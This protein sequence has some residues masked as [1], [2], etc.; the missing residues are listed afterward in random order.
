MKK[1]HD[2]EKSGRAK[3]KQ[4]LARRLKAGAKARSQRDVVLAADASGLED[5]LTVDGLGGP[6][7]SA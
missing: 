4:A 6:S 1:K 7:Q 5:L 2:N 3:G